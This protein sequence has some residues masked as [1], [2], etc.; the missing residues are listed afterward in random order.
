M[1]QVLEWIKNQKVL[2][3]FVF[4]GILCASFLTLYVVEATAEEA[5]VCP[6]PEETI[7]ETTEDEIIVDIK[8][9]VVNPGVYHVNEGMIVNDIITLAGG[10]TED[11]DTS[12]LNLSKKVTNEMVIT[13]YTKDEVKDAEKQEA[14]VEETGNDEDGKEES[15]TG[16]VSINTATLEELMTLPG[17]GEAK[18][19][20]IIQY[21][22]SCGKFTKVEDL[23]NI[24]GI[25]DSVFAQL[26]DYITL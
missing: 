14:I 1:E 12:N 16:L 18:G 26:K 19:K 8:G 3:A 22:E 25:G 2:C 11:A 9:A 24:K 23:L 7:T 21:R 13:V 10:L 4:L 17:I 6:K 5:Y 15:T 20:T